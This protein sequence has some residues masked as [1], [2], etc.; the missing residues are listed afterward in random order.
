MSA[1]EINQSRILDNITI[2]LVAVDSEEKI[3]LWN[4]WMERHSGIAAQEALNKRIDEVFATPPSSAFLAALR[5][6]VS[7]GLP[8]VLSNA[9]HRSPLPLFTLDES[10]TEPVAI[11]QSITITSIPANEDK[12]FCLI[13]ITDSSTSIRREKMLRSH[14]EVLKKDATTDSLTGLYNRRFFDEHYKISLGQAIRQKHPLSIFMVDIDFFKQYNDYY[15]HPAG[16]KILIQVA[17]ALKSQISRSSDMLARYGGEEFVL[18]LPN[19][20]EEHGKQF[21]EKLIAAV[22]HLQL[23]HLKSKAEQRISISIGLS[24]YD[25]NKHREVSALID[26]A[27]TALYKAKQQGRNQACFLALDTLLTHRLQIRPS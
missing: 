23:P 13:Q 21:A 5:N 25:P 3:L 7:Y 16:D 26:A 20:T 9:L 22:N 27:D 2:G 24:T 1:I 18:V 19:M 10:F 17:S 15:G 11:H 12:R 14:S 6:T 8:A 4:A